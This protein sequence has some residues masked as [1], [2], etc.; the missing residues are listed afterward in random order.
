VMRQWA[1]DPDPWL[2]R[3]AIICQ[4]RS[5]EA[6]DVSLLQE[7]IEASLKDDGFFLRKGIGWALRQHA[8]TDPLWVREF[9]DAHPDLSP[10]S[11]R[12]ALKHL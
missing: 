10:L 5:K 8:R 1:T 3:T 9:V 4:L 12:E 11:R 2:R 7:A 6:T